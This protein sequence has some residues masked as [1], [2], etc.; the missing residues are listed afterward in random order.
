[1]TKKEVKELIDKYYAAD[2]DAKIVDLVLSIPEEEWD[3]EYVGSLIA[4]YNNTGQYKMALQCSEEKKALCEGHMTAWHYRVAWAYEQLKEYQ[5]ALEHIHT[6]LELAELEE[7]EKERIRELKSMQYR[8]EDDI[9]KEKN[10]TLVEPLFKEIE[11]KTAKNTIEID[12][13]RGNA[14]LTDSKLGGVPFLPV[15][16]EWP[17]GKTTGERL[18]LLIQL[19]F[20][21]I[22]K[23]KS[24]PEHGILQIF[25]GASDAFTYGLNFGQPMNQDN[26]R[27]IYYDDIS[28]PMAEEDIEAMLPEYNRDS[29]YLPLYNPKKSIPLRF[30]KS[31]M[32]MSIR[33]YRFYDSFEG[34]VR[35]SLPKEYHVEEYYDLPPEMEEAIEEKL[36]GDGSRLGGYPAFTQDDPRDGENYPDYELF[37]QIDS[38]NEHIMWGDMGIANFFIDEKDLKNRDFTKVLYNWDCS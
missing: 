24:Y 21:E 1:M 25:I 35:E 37:L 30:K 9:T 5:T 38:D 16:G 20:E 11:S 2:E 15:G 23:M 6:A 12:I 22:P 18:H 13:K 33:D 29:E 26:W 19:N 17:V 32:G 8:M 27:I 36:Y 14:G 28:N 34:F 7:A 31:K 3:F 10:K 4:A